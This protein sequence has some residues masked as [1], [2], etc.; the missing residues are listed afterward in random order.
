MEAVAREKFACPACGAEAHWNATQQA[1]V[2][3]YCGTT[4]P[5]EGPPDSGAAVKEHD[6]VEALRSLP[7]EKRGWKSD[8]VSVKCQS[9][10]AIS[11]LDAGRVAQRCEFCGSAQIVPYDQVKPPISPES[12][13][14]FKVDQSVVRD[15]LRRWYGS[16]WFAPNRLKSAA[17][18]DTLRGAYLPYWTFDARVHASW[19]AESGYHYYTTETYRDSN[20]QTRTRQVQHTRWERSSGQLQHFFDDDLICASRGIHAQLLRQIEPFPTKQLTP[21]TPSFVAG[22]VVEQYQLDLIGAA[23]ESRNRMEQQVYTMCA[24]QVP[25]DTHRNLQVQSRFSDQTFKHVLLPLWF[26]T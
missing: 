13:L 18:T 3:P 24:S 10:Q 8:K 14:P 1:L 9:C 19:T 20:G 23:Q 25:G 2:C 17:L 7:D 15:S 22:W 5:L 4:S 12:V 16:R 11:V 6:L 26:V 21:Y